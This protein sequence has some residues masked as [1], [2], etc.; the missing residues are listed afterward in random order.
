MHADQPADDL[1]RHRR[2]G[3]VG[4]R[5]QEF[6][7]S[8]SDLAGSALADRPRWREIAQTLNNAI[9]MRSPTAHLRG[10]QS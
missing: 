6:C 9:R 3:D 7:L 4:C 10:H 2:G 8:F 1:D 5:E